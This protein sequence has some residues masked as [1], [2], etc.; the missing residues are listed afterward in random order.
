MDNGTA[1]RRTLLLTLVGAPHTRTYQLLVVFGGQHRT[2]AVRV[3]RRLLLM[4]M[5]VVLVWVGTL[6]GLD[7]LVIVGGVNVVG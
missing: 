6:K 3:R 2:G 1:V 7:G 4:D 5:M